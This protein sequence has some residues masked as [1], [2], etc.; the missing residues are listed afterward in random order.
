MSTPNAGNVGCSSSLSFSLSLASHKPLSNVRQSASI[1]AS[2]AALLSYSRNERSSWPA[3]WDIWKK[4]PVQKKRIFFLK[5]LCQSGRT[6]VRARHGR[7]CGNTAV[8]S[9]K[10]S[11][12]SR[13][14][15]KYACCTAVLAFCIP[16]R[17]NMPQI[18][19]A[20]C[21]ALRQTHH[22]PGF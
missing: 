8:S 10:D 4:N 3:C 2:A 11:S 6:W 13:Q 9:C 12:L 16:T 5:D 17:C 22:R 14:F 21:V 15:S 18:F 19:L 20:T 1:S 7:L